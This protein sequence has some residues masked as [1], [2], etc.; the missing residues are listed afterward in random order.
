MK[1]LQAI[2]FILL[3]FG[4]S[5]GQ[6]EF[7]LKITKELCSEKYHGRGYVNEGHKLA[8][9]FIQ[10]KFEEFGLQPIGDSYQQPFNFDVNTFPEFVELKIGKEPLLVGDNFIVDANSGSCNGVYEPVFI[11]SDKDFFKF[12]YSNESRDGKVLVIQDIET[13][14]IDTNQMLRDWKYKGAQLAPVIFLTNKKYTWTVGRIEFEFPIIELRDS[15]YSD[16]IKNGERIDI[17]VQNKFVK[18]LESQN[19]IGKVEGKCKKKTI[20]FSAHYDHLGQLGSSAYF[21]GAN[22]NASGVAMLLY[23]AK[24]YSEHPPKYNMVFMAFGA[25]EVGLL[26][27]KH[28]VENPLFP[29]EEIKFLINLDI[30]GTG[31]EGITVVNGAVYTKQFKKLTKLNSQGEYLKKIKM[32][33]KAANSD[34]YFFSEAGVPS[35]FIY[36]MG[37]VSY[38]HDIHDRAETLPLNE[39]DDLARLLNAFVKK[40]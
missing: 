26:G 31:E 23:L 12:E 13:K 35:I 10:G 39:F 17:Y 36:T 4:L 37:G 27:S 20:V 38:Y 7:G 24:Y 29:L 6:Q 28:Y 18:Q 5:F 15:L 1:K 22:D 25:E 14:D 40:L 33:G 32:R 2:G 3:W 9:D 16:R 21:P 8:A 19:V 30:L 34:H 11:T